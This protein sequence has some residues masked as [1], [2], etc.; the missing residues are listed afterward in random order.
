MVSP[1]EWYRHTARTNSL[2]R[3]H[4]DKYN[5]PDDADKENRG[6]AAVTSPKKGSIDPGRSKS[7]T[8]SI[9]GRKKSTVVAA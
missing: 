8:R 2:R 6:R 4:K 5:D 3:I 1:I 7:K 9:F